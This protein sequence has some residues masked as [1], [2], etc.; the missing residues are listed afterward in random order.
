MNS[1]TLR[2]LQRQTDLEA[3]ATLARLS[4]AGQLDEDT[5]ICELQLQLEASYVDQDRDVRLWEDETQTLIAFS[6]L[7]IPE[8][9][10]TVDGYLWFCIHPQHPSQALE[11][12]IL[13][14]AQKRLQEVAYAQNKPANLRM[15]VNDDLLGRILLLEQQGFKLDRRFLTMGYSQPTLESPKLPDGFEVRSLDSSEIQA[16]VELYNESFIDHWNH[17]DINRAIVQP[18]LE[19]PSYN[20]ALNLIAVSPEGTF[21]AFC[22]AHKHPHETE[23]W[24]KLLGTRRGFRK[25]GLGKAMLLTGMQH[26]HQTGATTLKLGVDANSPTKATQLYE[27]I[28]FQ[29]WK[30]WVY[31]TKSL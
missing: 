27:S 5:S 3:I 25:M 18:W 1:L 16:W 9:G 22:Y 21:A 20:P 23:G 7:L 12:E 4:N 2:S 13:T 19:R 17:H 29:S 10:D 15:I 8:S 14:W 6:R 24:I 30:Q 11:I 26:L 31:Y 28:G